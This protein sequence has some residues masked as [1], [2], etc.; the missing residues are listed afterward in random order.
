MN[1]DLESLAKRFESLFIQN[2]VDKA[3]VFGAVARGTATRHSDIDLMIVMP[4]TKRFFDR[5]EPFNPLHD[6]AK[7]K[8]VD[9]LIYSPEELSAI[10]HRAFIKKIL[11]DG[12]TIYE[13]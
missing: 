5:Y 4:T 1:P 9:L 6:M 13:R 8:A 11:Q 2:N 3:I 7:P 10:S 12:I